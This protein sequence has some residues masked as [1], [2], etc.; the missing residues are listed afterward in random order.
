MMGLLRNVKAVIYIGS[1]AYLRL[2]YG[3]LPFTLV[4]SK[5]YN[6]KDLW[7]HMERI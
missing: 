5:P 6:H 7:T 4:V 2:I 3:T 1:P